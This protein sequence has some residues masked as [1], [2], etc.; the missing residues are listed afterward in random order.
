MILT[1]QIARYCGVVLTVRCVRYKYALPGNITVSVTRNRFQIP[2][3]SELLG[4]E[5]Y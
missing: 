2:Y 4:I 5:G 3:G 1:F